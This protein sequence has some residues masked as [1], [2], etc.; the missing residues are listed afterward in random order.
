M[1]EGT[2]HEARGTWHEGQDK[3]MD[4][5]NPERELRACLSSLSTQRHR[6]AEVNRRGREVAEWQSGKVAKCLP[7]AKPRGQ[8][9][10]VSLTRRVNENSHGWLRTPGQ[11]PRPSLH[12]LT[13]HR[14]LHDAMICDLV[15]SSPQG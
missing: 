1:A 15:H 9:D 10:G 2:G 13:M 14:P 11:Q 7:R 5:G 6:V 8:S 3:D 12:G 4:S